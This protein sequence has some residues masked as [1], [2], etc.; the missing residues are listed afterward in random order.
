MNKLI[1]IFDNKILSVLTILFI[2]IIPLYP[3]FPF[4][5]I[6]DTY[7]SIRLEDFLVAIMTVIFIIQALR[8][9]VYFN[10]NF[11]K[12]FVAFWAVVIVSFLF[13]Y[14]IAK[15]IDFRNIGILHTLRR[16]E[17][18]IPFFIAYS[19]LKTEIL[20]HPNLLN[21]IVDKFISVAIWT[22]LL[23][24]IYALGQRS[25]TLF[26]PLRDNLLWISNNNTGVMHSIFYFLF[27]FFDF[28][29]VQT[30]NAE[31]AKGH[32]LNLTPFSRISSTFAGHYDLA[33][34]LVFFI[35]I[36]AG[37][38][39]QGK[40]LFRN[41]TTYVLSILTLVLTASRISFGAFVASI[42]LLLVYKRKWKGLILTIF[43][44]IILMLLN[45]DMTERFQDMFQ[46]K[47]VFENVQTGTVIIDQD[48][49]T[50]ELPAGNQFVSQTVSVPVLTTKD[51]QDLTKQL[52]KKE[53]EE[54]KKS[55]KTM[56]DNEALSIVESKYKQ[57]Q[58]F[59]AKDV[60]AGDTSL[61]TRTQIEWPRAI[62]AFLKNP[63]IG[64]GPSSITESTDGD[65]FR[66]LGETGIIGTGLFMFILGF[67]WIKSFNIS[68]KINSKES[69]LFV[70]YCAGLIALFVNA[71]LI[72]VFEA[73]KVAFIF[74]AIAGIFM[75]YVDSKLPHAKEPKQSL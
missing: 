54:A 26:Q 29:A 48:L 69:Y 34:F 71:M 37:L 52:V 33:A 8:K 74:W 19:A 41:I 23:V 4:I 27:R 1:Q 38:I 36:I 53:I 64:T 9:K 45:K 47:R 60:I 55:G 39:M 10:W 73:S 15:T 28:P 61:T 63:I 13:N 75:A 30:M 2:V 67:I 43:L 62:N 46:K 59:V 72:D 22:V 21:K 25:A 51:K 66:W 3:K 12:L 42:V 50:S 44:T 7:I 56:S 6:P 11:I 58:N 14:F 20:R 40:N 35:P 5:Q 70:A 16:I 18:M 17:Y 57:L 24:C 31:F 32:L 49:S 68:R 65:Y